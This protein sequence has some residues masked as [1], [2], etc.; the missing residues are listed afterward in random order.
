MAKRPKDKKTKPGQG[1]PALIGI[2]TAR[3][4][5]EITSQLRAGAER[6]CAA[7]HQSG[8][9]LEV[10]SIEVPGAIEIPLAVQMLLKKGCQGVVALGAV[11]RG[12]TPHF[13]YVNQSV[14]RAL[15]QLILDFNRPVGFG[16]LT[17]ENWAQAEERV[18]GKHGHKGEEAAEA[19]LE[20][21]ALKSSL[22]KAQK[23]QDLTAKTL[24]APEAGS[25]KAKRSKNEK[26][27][28][29]KS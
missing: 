12:E 28:P 11:I 19:V 21:M 2:V 10:W 27:E 8:R 3:F 24:Q 15:T 22:S 6:V 25:A 14:E 26:S 13:E 18:G 7:H 1:K 4:N 23:P 9:S 17:V 5:A 20:M 16:V 29:K